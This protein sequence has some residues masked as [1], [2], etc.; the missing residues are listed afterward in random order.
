MKNLLSRSSEAGVPPGGEGIRD[1]TEQ[2]VGTGIRASLAWLDLYEK[3]V[4]S[5]GEMH[6]S[7]AEASQLGWYATLA[8]AQAKFLREMAEASTCA[9]RDFLK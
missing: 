9:A 3:A 5:F 8:G 4:K 2:V 6:Q 1:L 7:L